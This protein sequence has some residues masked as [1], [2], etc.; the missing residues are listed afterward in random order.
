MTYN[1]VNGLVNLA[2]LGFGKVKPAVDNGHMDSRQSF[3]IS[4]N[5]VRGCVTCILAVDYKQR[6]TALSRQN[7]LLQEQRYTT[8]IFMT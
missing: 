8:N 1:S 3:R 2:A 7:K 5:D 6:L 4:L